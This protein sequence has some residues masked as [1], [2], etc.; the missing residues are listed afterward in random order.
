MTTT[1]PAARNFRT[2]IALWLRDGLGALVGEKYFDGGFGISAGDFT[3]YRVSSV[4][5]TERIARNRAEG[6][7]SSR[8]EP[9]SAK[10]SVNCDSD[11]NVFCLGGDEAAHRPVGMQRKVLFFDEAPGLIHHLAAV[12]FHQIE[13]D[14]YGQVAVPRCARRQEQHRIFFAD[15]V[16]LLNLVEQLGAVCEL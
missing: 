6:S 7:W 3:D 2:Q 16:G 9:P 5:L 15:R 1:C 13:E 14:I 10:A 12:R 11:S 4:E 8:K